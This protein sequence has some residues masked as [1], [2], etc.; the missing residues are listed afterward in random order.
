MNYIYQD[1]IPGH[2][3]EGYEIHQEVV[4]YLENKY[5]TGMKA[6]ELAKLY[7]DKFC[8][9]KPLGIKTNEK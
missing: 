1:L 9:K 3:E 6:K 2:H 4:K 5:K 8:K 7:I